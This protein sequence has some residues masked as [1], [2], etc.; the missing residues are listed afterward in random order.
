MN[1]ETAAIWHDIECGTYDADLPLWEELAERCGDP[2][3]EL[4]C[5]TGR[6]ALHLA[7]RGYRVIGLDQDQVLLDELA[8]RAAGL[9]VEPLWANAL[10]FELD[11]PV[12]LALAPMQ[13]L[14][15]L[16]DP[17]SRLRCLRRISAALQPEGLLGVVFLGPLPASE[18][19]DPPLPDVRE[20]DGWIYSSQPMFMGW[21]GPRL[22]VKRVR[23][24][25]SP[26]GKLTSEEVDRVTLLWVEPPEMEAEAEAAGFTIVDRRIIP[27]TRDHMGSM[28]LV[29]ERGG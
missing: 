11:E 10:D 19:G 9:P 6:V 2:V 3:L 7:R 12:A 13:F 25:V 29:L 26:E 27:E 28:A 20:V 22:I 14:Q 18:P 8:E 15:L 24:T 16:R 21:V 23:Q 4:G 1:G 17:E 5:G